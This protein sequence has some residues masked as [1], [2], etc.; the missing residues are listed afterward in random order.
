[1]FIV[2][3]IKESWYEHGFLIL[4]TITITFLFLYWLFVT[5]KQDSGTYN[6]FKVK[7]V[8]DMG[9]DQFNK[10]L[11][12]KPVKH[13]PP[14]NSKGEIECRRVLETIFKQPFPKA[15]PHFLFNPV[16]G[17]NLELDMFNGELKL[18]CEYN[19]RQHYQFNSFMHRN[20]KSNFHNQQ[21][22]DKIKRDVCKKL[23]LHLIEVPYTVKHENIES[24]I[25]G[26]LREIN[27]VK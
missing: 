2:N 19:G 5:R 9:I 10:D 16:T 21:Y 20:N 15:R 7:D 22:R 12:A 1:M 26:K 23:G 18:A 11:T 6:D 4:F 8:V 14:V 17:E 3:K 24:F 25:I 27:Y 13:S